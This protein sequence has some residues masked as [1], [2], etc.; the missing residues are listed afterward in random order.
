MNGTAILGRL[1]LDYEARHDQ[2]ALAGDYNAESAALAG[3]TRIDSYADR[4]GL[5]EQVHEWCGFQRLITELEKGWPEAV[6]SLYEVQED[7]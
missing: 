7:N 6:R 1:R 2:A 3:I 4:F 5:A